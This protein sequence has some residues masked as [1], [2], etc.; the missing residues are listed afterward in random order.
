MKQS[1]F[2]VEGLDYDEILRCLREYGVVIITNAYLHQECKEFAMDFTCR[3]QYALSHLQQPKP[4]QFKELICNDP[5]LWKLRSEERW[6]ELWANLYRDLN[7]LPNLPKVLASI[8][9]VNIKSDHVAPWKGKEDWAHLDQTNGSIFDCIQGQLVFSDTTARFVCSPKSHLIFQDVMRIMGV[10]P[11]DNSN[12]CMIS[13]KANKRQL[14]DIKDALEGVGGAW[15]QEIQARRGTAIL[16]LSSV[17]HSA[18]AAAKPPKAYLPTGPGS[19]E[20]WRIVVYISF[21]QERF[22]NK[23]LRY[24]AM[25]GNL[26]TNHWCQ[27]LWQGRIIKH[28]QKMADWQREP[29]SYIHFDADLIEEIILEENNPN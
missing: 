27:E 28:N 23:S 18:V 16:W 15:Q 14:Q 5:A 20:L 13:K 1:K 24:A 17:I 11:G 6:S 21:V 22:V 25:R 12:W 26:S 4:G 7:D 2:T 19:I 29:T 3:N 10:K 8:D 9:G